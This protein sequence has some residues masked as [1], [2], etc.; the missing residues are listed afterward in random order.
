MVQMVTPEWYY[1]WAAHHIAMFALTEADQKAVLA[2]GA[3]W[4]VMFASEDLYEATSVMVADDRTPRWAADQRGVILRLARANQGKELRKQANER[5]MGRAIECQECS[6][7]GWV[8]VPHPGTD[9]AGRL[10][11]HLHMPSSDPF[12]RL[13]FTAG[14][15]M[16]VHCY[17]DGGQRTLAG[18][19]ALNRK[20]M[21]LETYGKIYP[22]WR[23]VADAIN[24][25]VR[26]AAS[27]PTPQEVQR[28][29]Q[30]VANNMRHNK[31]HPNS[32]N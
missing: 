28:L 27:P 7:T 24:N 32:L 21:S 25:V 29:V 30:R 19:E 4:S 16:A 14:A 9:D 5:A 2:W 6:G 11:P 22:N 3:Q 12:S 18:L 23:D 1:E 17:C 20:P 31:Q 26:E 15:T 10:N 8:I 13:S